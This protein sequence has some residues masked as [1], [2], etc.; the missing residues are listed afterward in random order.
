M[1]RPEFASLR[2][3]LMRHPTPGNLELLAETWHTSP[4]V[5]GFVFAEIE[6]TQGR[7]IADMP[8]RLLVAWAEDPE[9][10]R[11]A[12]RL[13]ADAF[14]RLVWRIIN[15]WR[16]TGSLWQVLRDAVDRA[17]EHRRRLAR[18]MRWWRSVPEA[19]DLHERLLADPDP[20]VS[21]AARTAIEQPVVAQ[22]QAVSSDDRPALQGDALER[23]LAV[24]TDPNEEPSLRIAA[25]SRLSDGVER[26]SEELWERLARVVETDTDGNV[27]DFAQ[28]VLLNLEGFLPPEGGPR[29]GRVRLDG[30]PVGVLEETPQGSR[31]TYDAAWLAR[32]DAQPI[33]LTLPLRQAPYESVGLHPFF[34]NLLPEG[35]L[36]E[37]L[38]HRRKIAKNDRFGLLLAACED[39]VGAVEIVEE[40]VA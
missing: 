30:T 27:A 21:E 24:A 1:L 14:D 16:P 7:F 23:D 13:D 5:R 36:L 9:F 28:R 33:S 19:K 10:P 8:A 12:R 31:F 6:R 2:E 34:E 15:T 29:R 32:A 35:W 11:D 18:R 39:T 40:G 37:L 38:S 20:R 3:A 25:L 26:H 22:V 17:P 4:E